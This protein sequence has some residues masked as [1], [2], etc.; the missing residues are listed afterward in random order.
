MR[1]GVQGRRPGKL[2]IS[3][4]KLRDTLCS[5]EPLMC[6]LPSL[7]TVR[8]V[9]LHKRDVLELIGESWH[10]KLIAVSVTATLNVERT[11]FVLSTVGL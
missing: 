9:L 10:P 6:F 8:F 2:N 3:E 11:N 5:S 4:L 1:M 7:T